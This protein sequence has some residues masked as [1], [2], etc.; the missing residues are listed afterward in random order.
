MNPSHRN[1]YLSP[2][3]IHT[4]NFLLQGR[5]HSGL[6]P[7]VAGQL[8][9]EEMLL[10]LANVNEASKILDYG[11]GVGLVACDYK[12]LRGCQVHGVNNNMMQ[13]LEARALVSRLSLDGIEFSYCIPQRSYYDAVICTESLCHLDNIT[14][15]KVIRY[16]FNALKPGGRLVIEDWFHTGQPQEDLKSINYDYGC[17]LS[18]LKGYAKSVR[19][20][21]FNM[22][23]GEELAI[24]W[25]LTN[26][27]TDIASMI[28]YGLKGLC[29]KCPFD[30]DMKQIDHELMEAGY[31]I[32]NSP[33]FYV[34][35]LTATKMAHENTLYDII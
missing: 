30:I 35:V 33:G 27:A 22:I 24:S 3:T 23:K 2:K 18:T 32:H 6:R 19:D 25:D 10:D 9:M 16:F 12:Q 13:M 7:T 1:I 14:R 29:I 17:N 26:V 31:R 4:F 20:A 5:W 8:E 34:G 11:C 15:N 28:R 21:G